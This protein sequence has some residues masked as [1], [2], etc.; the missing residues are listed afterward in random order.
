MGDRAAQLFEQQARNTPQEPVLQVDDVWQ[1]AQNTGTEPSFRD[2]MRERLAGGA[3]APESFNTP[4][5]SD[6]V[7]P[8]PVVNGK[9]TLRYGEAD[10][11]AKLAVNPNYQQLAI[12]GIP[13]VVKVKH[14]VDAKGY[15]FWLDGSNE[16]EQIRGG[17]GTTPYRPKRHYYSIQAK[18]I[19]MNDQTRDL[20]ATR[21][22]V[23]EA[24]AAEGGFKGFSNFQKGQQV[25][26]QNPGG[27]M[28]GGDAMN[29]FLRMSKTAS[30]V[31]DVQAKSLEES[32]KT[33]DNPYFK[34][35]LADVY[36]AQAMRPIMDQVRNGGQFIELNNPYTV[37]KLDDALSLLKAVDTDS[38]T[39][40]QRVNR[41][42]P[43]N[44]VMPLDPYRIY[45]DQRDPRFP[46]YY[47]GF[48]GGSYDQA[49]H[50]EAS[51]T[52][53]R[54]LIKNNAFPRIELP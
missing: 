38:R 1:R 16:M 41:V 19:Q 24:L 53:I 51:I 10:F 47:Y 31:L 45:G 35:Y 23:N 52:F 27:R 40:L 26:F 22:K 11:D 17:D 18:E 54:N 36:T 46:E 32:V 9:L 20:E 44:A 5:V 2:R 28:V 37:K 15:F 6:R 39:G 49:K 21:L 48:W 42:P 33:S 12:Q 4:R 29:Y 3:T 43:G 13:D 14:F 8:D 7:I 30:N 25:D 50:R 34:I